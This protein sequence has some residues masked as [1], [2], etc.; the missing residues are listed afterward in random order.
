MDGP[1]SQQNAPTEGSAVLAVIRWVY[2]LRFRPTSTGSWSL[3]RKGPGPKR[4]WPVQVLP[5]GVLTTQ[6][7]TFLNSKL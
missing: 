5:L 2:L 4:S 1:S 3:A 6:P 7:G